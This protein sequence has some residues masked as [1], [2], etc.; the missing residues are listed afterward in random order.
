MGTFSDVKARALREARDMGCSVA[1]LDGI[2]YSN[3]FEDLMAIVDQADGTGAEGW[4]A[5]MNEHIQI[6]CSK[7]DLEDLLG[8]EVDVTLVIRGKLTGYYDNAIVLEGVGRFPQYLIETN[9]PGFEIHSV[10]PK[11]IKS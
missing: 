1:L 2:R 7:P 6:T 9:Q 10:L 3:S 5:W 8:K 4:K 11:T